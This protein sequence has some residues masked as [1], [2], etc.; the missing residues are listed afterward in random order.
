[1]EAPKSLAS[2]IAI[3]SN[4]FVRTVGLIPN[5]MCNLRRFFISLILLYKVPVEKIQRRLNEWVG[6]NTVPDGTV[7]DADTVDTF[8]IYTFLRIAE[9]EAKQIIF[10]KKLKI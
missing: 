2:G 10:D 1:M 3:T 8:L 4:L 5:K 7:V 9:S 6:L